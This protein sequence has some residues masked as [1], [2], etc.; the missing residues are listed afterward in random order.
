MTLISVIMPF[1][2][3]KEYFK[4]SYNSV[5]KQSYKNLEIIIVYDDDN[6]EDL[7]FLQDQI[8]NDKKSKIIQNHKNLGVSH[9]RNIGIDNSKGQIIAFLDCDDVWDLN[10]LK[11]QLEFM[12]SNNIKFS[13]TS[14]KLIDESGKIYGIN[15][16]SKEISY[17]DLINSC[18]IGL[19]S[20]MI[21]KSLL[22]IH[23]F[24]NITTK[25]DYTL[26]LELARN[27]VKIYGIEIP[28][29]YWRKTKNSLSSNIYT[30]F[31]NAFKV[32]HIYEKKNL[33]K[34]IFLVINLGFNYLKKTIKQKTFI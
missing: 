16:A 12:E 26:W 25:E 4:E 21:D 23:K 9:S 32:Y 1:Y 28:L 24:K 10:K 33:F 29:M 17:K 18:D 3:K 6:P 20:V 15:K 11:I 8:I 5:K 22:S 34:S 13:H 30:K 19:S 14:Y 27:N 7:S 31:L 2:K